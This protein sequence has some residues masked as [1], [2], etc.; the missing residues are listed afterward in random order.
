[1]TEI[2]YRGQ[3]EELVLNKGK[4]AGHHLTF[5]RATW[6]MVRFYKPGFLYILHLFIHERLAVHVYRG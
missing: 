5:Y 3:E 6:G 2:H 1:M 4:Y